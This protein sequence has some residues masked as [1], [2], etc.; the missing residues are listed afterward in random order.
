MTF[1]ASHVRF[2]ET[3]G[4]GRYVYA[5]DGEEAE[6]T[7]S[8]AGTNQIIIDHTFVPKAFRGQGIGEALVA[9]AVDAARKDGVLVRPLCPFTAAQFRQHPEWQ[10]LLAE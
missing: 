1:D 2:E 10:D 4:K 6:L 3:G 9:H 7:F 8:R 5:L